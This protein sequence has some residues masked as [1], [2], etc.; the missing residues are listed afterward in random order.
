[1]RRVAETAVT[2]AFEPTQ[3]DHQPSTHGATDHG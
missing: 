2:T 3:D 1:V